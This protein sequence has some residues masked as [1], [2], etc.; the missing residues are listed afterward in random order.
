MFRK[1]KSDEKKV[2][3]DLSVVP[4]R[5]RSKQQIVSLSERLH[6]IIDDF[7]CQENDSDRIV[8]RAEIVGTIEFLKK[9]YME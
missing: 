3:P 5:P 7:C 8:T 9:R 2:Q 6:E 4:L 1:S